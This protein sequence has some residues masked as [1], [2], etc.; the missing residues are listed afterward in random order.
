MKQI[1]VICDGCS[2][3]IAFSGEMPQEEAERLKSRITIN[4]FGAPR[5]DKCR[6][7]PY[8]DI[9]LAHTILITQFSPVREIGQVFNPPPEN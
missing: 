7:E 9:N 6:V 1:I 8:S 4:P 3:I 5:C 2:E